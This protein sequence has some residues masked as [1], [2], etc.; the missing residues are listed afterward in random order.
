MK[1]VHLKA[2]IRAYIPRIAITITLLAVLVAFYGTW[3]LVQAQEPGTTGAT[4]VV[5]VDDSKSMQ[6]TDPK[7]RRGLGARLLIERLFP[8]DRI[9]TV[10]F[11]GRARVV[12][13]LSP[14]EGDEN[15]DRLKVSYQ[16]LRSSGGSD[17]LGALAAAFAELEQDETDNPKVVVFLTDG[18]LLASEADSPEYISAFNDLLRSY[19]VNEW[20]VFP[21][22]FGQ[23]VDRRF[24]G[25]IAEVTGGGTCDATSESE[26]VACFQTV[27]DTFKQ[28]ERVLTVAPSCL[29]AGDVV[30]HSLYVD[31]FARQLSVVVAR[32]DSSGR[33]LVLDPQGRSVKP[34][35]EEGNYQFVNLANPATH[36]RIRRPVEVVPSQ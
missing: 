31:P 3:G 21:I 8:E 25:N 10:L 6:A 13:P 11:S 18:Q 12:S 30:D 33:T 20:P 2:S 7:L 36:F 19:R 27:L 16:L 17:M 23:D 14:V 15:R 28:A 9:A 35:R 29:A 26:L 24:L 1:L 4:V 5:V 34:P 22:S 32:E